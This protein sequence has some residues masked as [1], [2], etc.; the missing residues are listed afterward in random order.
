MSLETPFTI[1]ATYWQ[2]CSPHEKTAVPCP[3]C[4][5]NKSIDVTLGSGEVVKVPCEG[6]GLGW[7][8][9]RGYIEEHSLI[10][11]VRPFTIQSVSAFYGDGMWSVSD[12]E[13]TT[14][15]SELHATEFDA[16][17]SAIAQSEALELANI[18]TR[19]RKR[20][21]TQKAGWHI[22]YHREQIKDL[23]R[24][25]EWHRSKVATKRAAR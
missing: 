19:V 17:Q 21:E 7:D 13:R 18:D 23:E 16:M 6:C 11:R 25:L 12:G 4:A 8:G 3:V 15:F 22:R 9:P 24:K 5:G 1:G 20:M 14:Q 10:P 2:V